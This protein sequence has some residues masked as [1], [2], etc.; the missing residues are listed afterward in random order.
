MEERFTNLIGALMRAARISH[1]APFFRA[2]T[3]GDME[4]A[5]KD[6]LRNL[7]ESDLYEFHV[8]LLNEE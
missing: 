5:V 1:R 2:A 6:F 4:E 8:W 3:Q 7:T